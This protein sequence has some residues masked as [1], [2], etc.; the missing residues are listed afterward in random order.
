MPSASTAVLIVFAVNIAEHVPVPGSACL[1]TL[2]YCCSS[3]S[4]VPYAPIA[5]ITSFGSSPAPPCALT[6]PPHCP[7]SAVPP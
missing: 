3:I 6:Q 2:S 5:S 7:G 4:P 1:Y